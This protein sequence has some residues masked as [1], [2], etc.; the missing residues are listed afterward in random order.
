M[1]NG[2]AE[3]AEPSQQGALKA[4]I[5]SKEG[6]GLTGLMLSRVKELLRDLGTDG[7]LPPQEREHLRRFYTHERNKLQLRLAVLDK[8]E[9]LKSCENAL[10]ESTESLEAEATLIKA[11]SELQTASAELDRFSLADRTWKEPGTAPKRWELSRK[12]EAITPEEL[13]PAVEAIRHTFEHYGCWR[14]EQST[15]KLCFAALHPASPNDSGRA[16]IENLDSYK[17]FLIL[18]LGPRVERLLLDANHPAPVIFKSYLDVLETALK[19]ALRVSFKEMFEIAKARTDLLGMHPVEWA[20]RHL[21][22]LISDEKGRIRVWIKEVCDPLDLSQSAFTDDAIF[23][24]SWRAP[25]LIHM[26]PAGNTFYEQA[27]T[28]MREELVESEELVEARAE[29]STDFL[30]IDL[31]EVA[32]LAHVEFAKQDSARVR[33]PRQED[34]SRGIPT[35]R[36]PPLVPGTQPPDVWRSLHET[37]RGLAEEELSLAPHNTGDRWLRAYVDYKDRSVMCGQWH[38]SEGVNESF[39][40]RFEVEAT[41]AGIALKSTMSGEAGKVWLHHVFL[42]LLEHK[43]K[44][45]FAASNDGGTVVRVCEASA[46]YCARLE[47]QALVEGIGS[48]VSAVQGSVLGSSSTEVAA[49]DPGKG[50]QREAVIKKVQNPHRYNVL[51]ILEAALYFEVQPR[52][53]YRWC[54]EGD[55]RAGARRGSIT[56]ES[57][58]KLE[59]RRSRKRRHH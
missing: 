33:V 41:R 40:E 27:R 28:W 30:R 31:D 34:S 9:K 11:R 36:T 14:S 57:I 1:P 5:P 56:I 55:L 23:W 21:Q 54:L 51:S 22:I 29:L 59:K 49:D 24:G 6:P 47:K 45:L 12:W 20:K 32:R 42:D 44:L 16:E 15:M 10:E 52:T 39:H 53:I 18:L 8:T 37:F 48:T 19:I 2:G 50:T 17:R 7:A 35:R 13:R 3:Q 58:L 43:S 38:L 4:T 46:L 25:R 26:K